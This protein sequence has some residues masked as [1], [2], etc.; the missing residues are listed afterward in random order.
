LDFKSEI[1]VSLRRTEREKLRKVSANDAVTVRNYIP[2]PFGFVFAVFANL[3]HRK[4]ENRIA[5]FFALYLCF[6]LAR[7]YAEVL[8]HA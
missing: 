4:P 2:R 6:H 5:A 7:I 1:M 8:T 3:Q